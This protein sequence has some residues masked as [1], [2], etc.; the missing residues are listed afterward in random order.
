M[1]KLKNTLRCAMFCQIAVLL[2]PCHGLVYLL[3]LPL[4][5][6]HLFLCNIKVILNKGKNSACCLY[7]SH[8]AGYERYLFKITSSLVC[9]CR[10]R[11][12]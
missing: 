4:K 6:Q 1:V 8:E 12:Y 5:N 2:T 3:Q 9:C 11:G 10:L 7:R